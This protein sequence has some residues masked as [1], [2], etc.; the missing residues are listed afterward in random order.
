MINR[1]EIPGFQIIEGKEWRN[2]SR[3][4]I[5]VIKGHIT[6]MEKTGED[7]DAAGYTYWFGASAYITFEL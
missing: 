1:R 4:K 6:K 2:K 3:E 5:R 7:K